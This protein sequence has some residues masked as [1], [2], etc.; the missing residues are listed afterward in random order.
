MRA[1]A[2]PLAGWISN[3]YFLGNA[4]RETV[5]PKDL[6]LMVSRIDGSSETVVRRIID[7]S[8][9][10][11]KMGLKGIAYF[12]ARWPD[13]RGEEKSGYAFYDQSIHLAADKIEDRNRM[14]VVV[15]DQAALFGP[16]E[17]PQAAL[18][19][20]WYSLARYIDA[21]DWQ[22]GAVGYHIAS[23]ECATLQ[24]PDFKGWCKM[25]IEDGA[26][27]TIGPVS[28]P[29]VQ[30]FP[31]P[32]VFFELLTEGYLSLVEC[33]TVSLPVLSWKMVLIGDPLYRPFKRNVISR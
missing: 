15:N 31:V 14:P 3:P 18:Y 26:A 25:M 23:G 10:A 30:A 27:A 20:G 22:R 17:C 9:L 2:Y 1:P 29:F 12:D 28:E 32:E 33:Y 11:E 13:T 4:K 21:F 16:G 8:I 19:C 6:A 7:D 24:R 5:V